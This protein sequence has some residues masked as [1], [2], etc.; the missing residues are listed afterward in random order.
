MSNVLSEEK[1]QQVL[2]LGRL[3][4]SLRKIQKATRIRRETAS[5]YLKAA[6]IAVRPPGG[7]GRRAAKPAINNEVITDFGV[8]KPAIAVIT[9]PN[10]NPQTNPENPSTKE[11]AT[12]KP[13][14]EVITDSEVITDPNC[15]P[16]Q[17][18]E[19]GALSSEQVAVPQRSPSASACGAYR[20]V[21]ELGLS[22]GRSARAIW[23]DRVDQHGFAS[24]YQSVQR[25]VRQLRGTQ[26]PEARVVIVTAP[27]QE[28]QVD[29]GTG[30]LLK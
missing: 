14:N 23:Q 17:R 21:I 9:N 5:R 29:Y 11:K 10:R 18:D 20:E 4:W 3:G 15:N 26:A 6:G 13:A 16:L 22:R 8:G 27:G 12:S 28:A 7:W 1:K 24:S 19:V 2:A 30:P 25:F